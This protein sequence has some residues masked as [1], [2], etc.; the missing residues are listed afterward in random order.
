M[1]SEFDELP[2]RK[3]LELNIASILGW[4][5]VLL[6]GST[7]RYR[8]E[9]MNL[10]TRLEREKRPF[11]VGI[12]HGRFFVFVH[13]FRGRGY[14]ALVSQH[15]DGEMIA[16]TILRLGFRTVRG[17]ST[18]GGKEAFHRMVS[19]LRTGHVGVIIPDGPT[20][21][22]HRLKPGI[23]Y[24][25]QQTGAAIV[26]VTFGARRALRFKSWDRFVVPLP[27]TRVLVK[28]G[29]PF[30]ISPEASPKDIARTKKQLEE[31]MILQEQKADA[32]VAS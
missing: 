29:P 10:L 30:F 14:V 5:V 27:F 22:R 25:A 15:V 24:M 28:A 23:V 4:F 26:P 2:F 16:R 31:A 1:P 20:G 21:P 18:R 32:A 13:L 7:Y 12:W 19:L 17:S 3:R 8:F 9:G 6:F 11:L